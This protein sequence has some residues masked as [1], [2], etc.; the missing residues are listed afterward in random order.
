MEDGEAARWRGGRKTGKE[1][2]RRDIKAHASTAS[3]ND[4]DVPLRLST[5]GPVSTVG[6]EPRRKEH[7]HARKKYQSFDQAERGEHK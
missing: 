6:D 2:G 1:E 7:D 5:V 4:G 3:R